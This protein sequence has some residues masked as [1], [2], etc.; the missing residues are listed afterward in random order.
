MRFSLTI[1]MFSALL[2]SGCSSLAGGLGKHDSATSVPTGGGILSQLRPKVDPRFV[3]KAQQEELERTAAQAAQA[4]AMRDQA[5]AQATADGN[6]RVLPQVSTDPIA[7]QQAVAANIGLPASVDT[8]ISANVTGSA[9]PTGV[10]DMWSGGSP[11]AP[12][13][14]PQLVADARKGQAATYGSYNGTVPPPP[15]GSLAGGSLTPPPPAVTLSTQ[16]NMQGAD[17]NNPYGN[18]YAN[19]YV[20]P[21]ANPYL[22]P[23]AVPYQGGYPAMMPPQ[24]PER[25]AGLF[26]SGQAVPRANAGSD[27]P[28][29]RK[30][31]NFI[32]ITPTGMEARSPYKQRDDLKVLWKGAQTGASLQ[33]FTRDAKLAENLSKIDV[34]LPGDATKGSFSVGQRQVDTIFKPV[35]IDKRIAPIVRR[36]QSDLVQSYYRYLYTYNKFALAQQTSAAR[37]QEAEVANTDS[38]RQRALA[39]Q[40][41]A[42]NEADSARE[43][44]KSAQLELAN[45]AGA[46]AARSIIGRV[47]GITPTP[48]SLAAPE[49][50][51]AAQAESKGMFGLP[52]IGS[53]FSFGGKKQQPE[54]DAVATAL[55]AKMAAQ[56]L[57]KAARAEKKD[58]VKKEKAEAKKAAKAPK[59][60]VADKNA[61]SASTDKVADLA[62]APAAASAASK[63]ESAPEA[64]PEPAA[65]SSGVSVELQ[66][67]NITARKS[68]LSVVIK[69]SGQGDFSFNADDFSV[70]ENNHKLSDAAMRAD[71][72]T[73]LVQP[74]QEVKGTITIFGRPWS[75]RLTVSL[76]DG[77]R[78]VQMKR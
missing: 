9:A 2:L 52:S 48:D 29:E 27:A 72:D 50:A 35:L 70:A 57:E 73:T 49:P 39:D 77:N 41:Q 26:G 23:Y 60:A 65:P 6:G 30:R 61:K 54:G 37:K 43:D 36:V 19:P 75:P 22:N 59:N 7:S 62:P 13:P 46:N 40:A 32:P 76:S 20:N 69:N 47:S 34:S 66:G 1:V 10:P 45:A 21:Y 68:T 18:P 5:Q 16:A 44:M 71:F 53:L 12:T 24:Q 33:Q 63:A 51:Q 64:A 78:Q 15:P 55:P 17:P 14:P 56:P 58:E 38:E 74:N 28:V 42:Q 31:A 8:S 11:I 3:A 25:P 67:V 4:Q